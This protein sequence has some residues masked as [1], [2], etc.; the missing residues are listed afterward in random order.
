MNLAERDDCVHPLRA[1]KHPV[2]VPP[3]VR[4][5]QALHIAS[6]LKPQVLAPLPGTGSIVAGCP[7]AIQL[8]L[9]LQGTQVVALR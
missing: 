8:L 3:V 5:I 6:T 7:V 2:H 4:E 1:A 9:D